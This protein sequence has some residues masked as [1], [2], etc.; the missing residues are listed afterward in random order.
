LANPSTRSHSQQLALE[1]TRAPEKTEAFKKPYAHRAGIEGT[2]SL[3]VR[4]FDLRRTRFLGLAKTH[5]QYILVACA[6]NLARLAR[7]I[8]GEVPAQPS[9]TAFTRLI[10]AVP[11]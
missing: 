11:A 9:A 4:T 1:A 7:W 6:I 10:Q 2:I 3:G 5:L 8:I